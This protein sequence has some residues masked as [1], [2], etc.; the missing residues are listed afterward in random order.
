MMHYSRVKFEN[1]GEPRYY[2]MHKHCQFDGTIFL[3]VQYLDKCFANNL[4]GVTAK[5]ILS[6]DGKTEEDAILSPGTPFTAV[7]AVKVAVACY[8]IA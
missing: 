7:E 1:Q 2:D 6:A 8:Y 3:A 5:K 4:S